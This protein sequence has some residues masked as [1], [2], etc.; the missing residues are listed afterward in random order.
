MFDIGTLDCE[1]NEFLKK[2]LNASPLNKRYDEVTSDDIVKLINTDCFNPEVAF[3][4]KISKMIIQ[5]LDTELEIQKNRI[6]EKLEAKKYHIFSFTIRPDTSFLTL[7]S[8]PG[9]VVFN[10]IGLKLLL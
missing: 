7:N 8:I 9:A 2:L 1:F 3:S 4:Q 6:L 10:G 5:G